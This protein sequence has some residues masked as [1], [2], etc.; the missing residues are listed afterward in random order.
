MFTLDFAN[1][2]EAV[3]NHII[4]FTLEKASVRG[5]LIR[6]EKQ[7][8]QILSGHR[9][10]VFVAAA[11]GELLINTAMLGSMLK[12]DGI[13]SIQISGTGLIKF[14]SADYT[15]EG[16][17]RGYAKMTELSSKDTKLPKQ[18]P[19]SALQ[20]LFGN[21]RMVVTIETQNYAPYQAIISLEGKT[22]SDCIKNYF[23]SS[24]QLDSD[25]VVSIKKCNK[26]WSAG[27]I[28][29]Q[30]VPQHGGKPSEVQ[31]K[32]FEKIWKKAK[33]AL[34]NLDKETLCQ[35][36]LVPDQLLEKI[37]STKHLE[38]FSGTA[39][40]AKCRCSRERMHAALAMLTIEERKTLIKKGKYHVTCQ[41]C[42]RTEEFTEEEI[43][44][45]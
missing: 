36:R 29:I 34:A 45:S 16:H 9:Y 2:N 19:A 28:I 13:I 17:I 27:G 11:L 21:G 26:M 15:S 10:P 22:I 6:L 3:S 35:A 42:H 37:F 23:K 24:D 43:L 14:M 38:L 18:L 12:L 33:W 44:Q 5:R 39:I 32:V 25:I 7:I 1:I 31:S 40:Q 30:K 41:I 4:P 8:H 20:E